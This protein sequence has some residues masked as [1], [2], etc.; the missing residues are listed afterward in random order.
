VHEN[1]KLHLPGLRGLTIKLTTRPKVLVL[2]GKGFIG[3]HAVSALK[4][5][6]ADIVVGSR[7]IDKALSYS[8]L[9][10]RFELMLEASDWLSVI[11][12]Y[13]AVLNC[14]GI[15]RPVGKSTYDAVHHL[16]PAALAEACHVS[17]VRFVHVSALGL[18]PDAKSGFLVS[19]KSGE[20]AIKAVSSSYIIARPSLLDGEGG[21]G[22]AWLRGVS[23]LPFFVVPADAN[24][25]IAGL[26]V[27]DLGEALAKLCL[28]TDSVLDLSDSR[29]FELGGD[30]ALAF[31]DYIRELRKRYTQS[32]AFCLKIPGLLARLG[33]H[34]CDVFHATPF[35]FGHWELLRNNNTPHPNR[36]PQLLG[37]APLSLVKQRQVE[38]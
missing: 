10:V 11:K 25:L 4:V 13:D 2:G 37:R 30:E 19:K 20:N 6:G 22:A 8:Q 15:L 7:Q 21:Y 32:R 34:V 36:L 27:T 28:E 16:A 29:E 23:R 26:M 17:N 24:G 3:R 33:A 1:N 31:E 14:V 12:E 35:S 9:E 18:L 5:Q 38:K